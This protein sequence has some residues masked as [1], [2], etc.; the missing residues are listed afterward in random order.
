MNCNRKLSTF[1][2]F[3]NKLI[4]VF[5]WIKFK[6]F[7]SRIEGFIKK[8]LAHFSWANF[9]RKFEMTFFKATFLRIN[10]FFL[11]LRHYDGTPIWGLAESSITHSQEQGIFR[12]WAMCV[13]SICYSYT[14]AF[15]ESP[16]IFSFVYERTPQCVLPNNTSFI[17]PNSSSLTLT[18]ACERLSLYDS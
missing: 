3:R 14:Y 2:R 4:T 11:Q 5:L 18:A 1:W 16:W 6:F 12:R 7:I 17:Q 8:M 15:Q 9:S 13:W 10:F